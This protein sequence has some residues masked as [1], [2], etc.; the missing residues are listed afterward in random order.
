MPLTATQI[1]Q[2][3]KHMG[4]WPQDTTIDSSIKALSDG[5]TKEL[6]LTTAIAACETTYAAITTAET[7]S[8]ELVEGG[9][10]KF[11]YDRYIS[12]R[13]QAYKRSQADLARILGVD[14]SVQFGSEAWR[15]I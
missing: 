1:L 3:K 2:A 4:V 5:S 6:E 9:G 14:L 7:A 8:D 15:V 10:A 11:D 12:T 13:K